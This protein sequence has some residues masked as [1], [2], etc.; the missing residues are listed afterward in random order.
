M[1][2]ALV[3]VGWLLGFVVTLVTIWAVVLLVGT[4]TEVT[5]STS[6]AK[7][8]SQVLLALLFKWPIVLWVVLYRLV[9]DSPQAAMRALIKPKDSTDYG[10]RFKNPARPVASPTWQMVTYEGGNAMLRVEH[11]C[12]GPIIS[13]L[14]YRR[15]SL[16]KVRRIG[17][18]APSGVGVHIPSSDHADYEDESMSHAKTWVEEDDDFLWICNPLRFEKL[19]QWH[20]SKVL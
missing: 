11:Y 9:T 17:W 13:H 10:E 19:A 16:V 14:L 3:L 18:W 2:F 20:R 8:K 12:C 1:V 15:G 4:P 7:G 6:S 5:D